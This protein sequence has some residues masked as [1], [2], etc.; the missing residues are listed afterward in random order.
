M[1][2]KEYDSSLCS[3]HFILFTRHVKSV[4]LDHF[5]L[6]LCFIFL[7][8]GQ[9]SAANETPN[10]CNKS[11]VHIL[12]GFK[13]FQEP[14]FSNQEV[15]ANNLTFP[16]GFIDRDVPKP[17]LLVSNLKSK[18]E[19]GTFHLFSHGRPGEL[20]INGKWLNAVELAQWL[21]KNKLLQKV[22]HINIYGCNFAKGPKGHKAMT[23]LKTVLGVSTGASDDLTGKNGDWVL[24]AGI[25]Y[26]AI[27]MADYPF[28]LQDS[29][30]DGIPNV[31]DLD[32]DNDGIP[33]LQECPGNTLIVDVTTPVLWIPSFFFGG[34]GTSTL[35]VDLS[36]TGVSIG[37]QVTI[38]NIVATGDLNSSIEHFI[39]DFNFGEFNTG[40]VQTGFQGCNI[41]NLR[42]ITNP[43]TTMVTVID[44]GS[45]VPGIQIT[46]SLANASVGPFCSP[47]FFAVFYQLDID[48]PCADYDGDGIE[49]YLDLDSDGDGCNDVVEAGFTDGDNDGVLGSPPI[50][51]D[52]NGMVNSASDGYTTPVDVNSN[53]IFDFFELGVLPA[54]TTQPT[55]TRIIVG[56]SATMSTQAIGATNTY[57]W[58]VST[59]DGNNY[60]NIS[61]GSEYTGTNTTTL[62][63]VTPDINKNGNLYR[64][65]VTDNAYICNSTISNGATL[66]IGPRTMITNRGITIRVKRN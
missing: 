20:L 24:E 31:M 7:F 47:R 49:N 30:N 63:I 9:A 11:K 8:I 56:A 10:D 51:V 17:H 40:G 32:D 35:V 4:R 65:L 57:Q 55:N 39:L 25:P 12:N 46:G 59:D 42:P 41:N 19:D 58:Q 43:I 21:Q 36:G 27:A 26:G 38:S 61:D 52:A 1:H 64:A 33:D 5:L 50:T 18:E 45:G 22:S 29:D 15:R 54:I 28:N 14:P 60:S 62:N 66:T 48:I 53:G 37:T 44:I 16:N 34:T 3:S 2:L 23:Y 6:L 13:L